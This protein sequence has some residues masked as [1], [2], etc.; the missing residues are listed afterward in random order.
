VAEWAA[1]AA[2]A[3]TPHVGRRVR[4]RAPASTPLP[5]QAQARCRKELQE[6]PRSALAAA[7]VQHPVPAQLA[8]RA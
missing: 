8:Q 7:Q 1:S 3:V 4:R 5:A 2:A 6:L